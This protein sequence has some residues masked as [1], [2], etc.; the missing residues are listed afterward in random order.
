MKAFELLLDRNKWTQR[1]FARDEDGKYC[2]AGNTS[3]I[4]WCARGAI[5]KCYGMTDSRAVSLIAY[6]KAKELFNSTLMS[7]NDNLG[8]EAVMEVLT[9]AD[10]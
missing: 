6:K 4:C 1:A 7:V 10:V 9:K 8:Y 3:A 2:G 5:D